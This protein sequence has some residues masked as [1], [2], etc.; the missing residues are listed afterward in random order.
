MAARLMVVGNTMHHPKYKEFIVYSPSDIA[1][2][3]TDPADI[4]WG[5]TAFVISTGDVYILN[6][7]YVWVVI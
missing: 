5:A 4:S 1:D 2:L 6:S 7:K 3:P